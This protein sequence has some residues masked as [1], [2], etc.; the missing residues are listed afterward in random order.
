MKRALVF[1]MVAIFAANLIGCA[2][3]EERA[4]RDRERRREDAQWE[5]EQRRRDREDARRDRE[6]PD[7]RWHHRY[8]Y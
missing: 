7:Y 4:K 5:A 2:T 6:D 3:P 8:W 1:S